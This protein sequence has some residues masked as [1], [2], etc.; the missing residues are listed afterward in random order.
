MSAKDKTTIPGLPPVPPGFSEAQMRRFAGGAV[1][2]FPNRD[3]QIYNRI[4]SGESCYKLA[5]EMD[6]AVSGIKAI[7]SRIR[8]RIDVWNVNTG[9]LATQRL[10]MIEQLRDILADQGP[11]SIMDIDDEMADDAL[12]EVARVLIANRL[13]HGR[14]TGRHGW[15]H[16]RHKRVAYYKE[17]MRRAQCTWERAWRSDMEEDRAYARD[18]LLDVVVYGLMLWG[19]CAI[20]AG[21][22]MDVWGD[23]E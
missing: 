16:K 19:R 15:W 3:I 2:R 17:A 7:V 4:Q 14:A 5:R 11:Q 1:A 22:E 21:E 6:R 13:A 9:P 8:N 23:L 10:E 20:Q 12:V 18:E